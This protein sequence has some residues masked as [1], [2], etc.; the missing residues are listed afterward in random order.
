MSDKFF[1]KQNLIKARRCLEIENPTYCKISLFFLV[2]LSLLICARTTIA[3]VVAPIDEVHFEVLADYLG[4]T[5]VQSTLV[6]DGDRIFI[7]TLPSDAQFTDRFTL[8]FVR[9]SGERKYASNSVCSMTNRDASAAFHK[10]FS[11]FALA[12][13]ELAAV[14]VSLAYDPCFVFEQREKGKLA[15]ASWALAILNQVKTCGESGWI[16]ALDA[17]R[18]ASSEYLREK[19]IILEDESR[20]SLQNQPPEAVQSKLKPT[21]KQNYR[22]DPQS[23]HQVSV[24]ESERPKIFAGLAM[25]FLLL[26]VLRWLVFRPVQGD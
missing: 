6:A 14:Q 5:D 23:N 12:D 20:P 26:L 17:R 9:C 10:V 8:I 18:R 25:L 22:S 4:K 7:Q 13:Y 21:F 1:E 15:E 3:T 2:A 24:E 19:A 16:A 11:Q